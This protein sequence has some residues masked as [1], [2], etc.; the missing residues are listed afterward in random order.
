MRS[1]FNRTGEGPQ[2]ERT[3]SAGTGAEGGTGALEALD[4]FFGS[5]KGTGPQDPVASDGH[6]RE[7]PPP[8]GEPAAAGQEDGRGGL[9]QP[10]QAVDANRSGSID[11]DA[12]AVADRSPATAGNAASEPGAK[13][14]P[15]GDDRSSADGGGDPEDRS[16]GRL[17]PQFEVVH[18]DDPGFLDEFGAVKDSEQ[19]I[20]DWF[21]LE[22]KD[23]L[24]VEDDMFSEAADLP[25]KL[26]ERES[27]KHPSAV[28]SAGRRGDRPEAGG[29]QSFPDRSGLGAVRRSGSNGSRSPG[30]ANGNVAGE[31]GAAAGSGTEDIPMGEIPEESAAGDCAASRESIDPPVC[32]KWGTGWSRRGLA[33]VALAVV[34]GVAVMQLTGDASFRRTLESAVSGAIGSE[35][36]EVPAPLPDGILLNRSLAG[37]EGTYDDA[38]SIVRVTDRIGDPVPSLEERTVPGDAGRFRLQLVPVDLNATGPLAMDASETVEWDR[39]FSLLGQPVGTLSV[40]LG[41]DTGTL[42]ASDEPEARPATVGSGGSVRPSV[43]FTA[44]DGFGFAASDAVVRLTSPGG[45]VDHLGPD[46]P[47]VGFA[48]GVWAPSPMVANPAAE[49]GGA[50]SAEDREAAAATDFESLAVRVSGIEGRLAAVNRNVDEL[51]TQVGAAILRRSGA[52]SHSLFVAPEG[53]AEG[54]EAHAPSNDATY[55]ITSGRD[56]SEPIVALAEVKVGD[57]VDG[58]GRVFDIVEYGEGGRLLVMEEGSVYLN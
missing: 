15:E 5:G 28:G 32:R 45:D 2:R 14:G 3:A 8:A 12:E 23:P 50:G 10:K 37:G 13:A 53:L 57:R 44:D 24:D 55:V 30:E 49:L 43:E 46:L 31:S 33:V 7:A 51:R 18:P 34:G 56:G 35:F 6:G 58:F 29:R 16:S 36:G 19:G 9:P 26:A 42:D 39:L 47:P 21:A 1:E 38:G 25:S 22:T 17:G 40:E 48:D 4:R 54:L 41:N 27:G 11:D 52:K 20:F